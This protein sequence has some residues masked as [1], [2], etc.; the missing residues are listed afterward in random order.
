MR[1]KSAAASGRNAVKDHSMGNVWIY[2]Y[3]NCTVPCTLREIFVIEM[4][5]TLTITCRTGHMHFTSWMPIHDFLIWWHSD[6]YNICHHLRNIR[7]LNVLDFT[8][9]RARD[10]LQIYKSQAQTSLYISSQ[11]ECLLSLTFFLSLS[12]SLSLSLCLSLTSYYIFAI[13]IKLQTFYLQIEAQDRG[14]EK[15]DLHQSTES[16]LVICLELY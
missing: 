2:I 16:E 12:L 14:R 9:G 13:Q 1:S 8:F 3:D 10:K 4:C 6:C 15:Q 5:M 7:N 11:L